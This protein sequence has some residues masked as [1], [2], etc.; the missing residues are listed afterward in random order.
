MKIFFLLILSILIPSTS[1]S[2]TW[3]QH[4]NGRNVWSLAK[5]NNG[6]LYAG[7]LTSGNSRIWKSTDGG[8]SW[9]TIHIGAGQTMWDFA[10]DSQGTM[11]VANYST[12]MLKSTNY[13]A[14]FTLIPSSAFNNKNL[15]G[16]ECGDNGYIYATSSTG[17]FRSTDNGQTFTETALTGF[18]CL[19]VLVDIDS[20][21]IVY[22]G[23]TGAT[24]IGFYRSTNYGLTFSANLNPGKN[25]FN[26]VQKPNGEVYMITT[27]S[28]YNFDKTT[29]KGLTWT[30]VSNT[31]ASQRGIAYSLTQNFYTAGNGGVFRST[32]NGLT[33]NNFNFTVSATPVL[34]VNH[35][36][37]IK[38]L[39]GT[40]GAANGGVWICTE[41]P[42]PIIKVNLKV[43]IEGLY[44]PVPDK[45]NRRD[46]VSLYLRDAVP[47]YRMKDSAR[48]VIDTVSFSSLY[49]FLNSPTG[50]YYLVVRHFNSIETWS[51]SG[52]ESLTGDSSIFNY[53]FTSLISQ[54]FGNNMKLKGT[55][56]CVYSADVNQDGIVDGSDGAL[57]DND[58]F[59][60]VT[61]YVV[62]DVN[63]DFIVDG[64]DYLIADNNSA[65]FIGVIRP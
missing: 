6:N 42:A 35:N 12:G 65:A 18:N 31:A 51:K 4:I 39:T 53:D 5:D 34:S 3:T 36:S 54:A 23:V 9:D 41:G 25:G 11:Y 10:F 15:Q 63:G 37:T 30:T 26:L 28:P 43:L 40:S 24:A 33:F 14:S 59:N 16:V 55:R 21:N 58:A 1:F 29:N 60:F 50:L 38:I 7:G 52:G 44:F 45:L 49:T 64:S 8:D 47:P 17:F 2:Q 20:S 62:T 46:T 48:S 61:G 22:V 27:T 19:P 13:G 56:Y 32:D 57:V